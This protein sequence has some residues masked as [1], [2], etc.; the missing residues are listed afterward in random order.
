MSPCPSCAA[1]VPEAARFCSSCGAPASSPSSPTALPSDARRL[2]SPRPVGHV[3]TPAEGRGF[4][5]GAVLAERFRIIGLLGRGGMGEVY[6]ADDLKLGQPVALKFLPHASFQDAALIDRLH[7]EVRNARQI[8]HPSVCRVYDIGEVNGDHFITMEYVDG[9]DLATLLSRIGRLPG[10]KALEIARQLCGGLA[11]AHEKGVLHRDLKPANV[12][13]DGHGHARITDFGLALRTEEAAGDKSGTPA[14]MAPE[15]L[16]GKPASVRSDIYALGL[17]LYELYTGKPAF[18]A[19]NLAAWKRQ[20]SETE[21]TAPSSHAADVD[22]A[23]ERAILRCLEK[24]PRKRPGSALQ[25][26]AALP[27]GDPLAAA[28]AAGETPSPEMVAAAGETEGLRPVIAWLCLAGIV[29]GVVAAVL[30]SG[31]AKLYRRVPLEKPPEA[32]AERAKDVLRSVGHAEPPADSA[33]GFYEGNDFLR[34]VSEHDASK[35]R[36]DNMEYGPFAFW[37]RSSPRPLGAHDFAT[38]APT[39]GAVWTDDPPLDVSGM[40]LVRLTPRGHLVQLVVVP[41]QVEDSPGAAVPVDWG[42]LFVAAGLD[43]SKWTSAQST[44]TP[45]VYSDTRA[46]WTGALAERPEMPMRIEAAAYRGKPVYFQLIGPMT[47]PEREQAYKPTPAERAAQVAGIFLLLLL[48][49][50]SAILARRNLRLGRGDRRGAFRLA[51]VVFA[52]SAVAFLLGAH[53]VADFYEFALFFAAL[54]LG[55]A[56]SFYIGIIYIALEPYVRRRWPA[57][58]ISWSRLLAGGVLDPL[59]GRDVLF[60]CLLSITGICVVRL[61]WFV[62]LWLGRPPVQPY[63]GPTWQ[64]LGARAIIST[65]SNGIIFAILAGLASL[66]I[67]F[68]FRTLLRKD[69]AAAV[70]FVLFVGLVGATATGG[71]IAVVLVPRLILAAL[72]VFL[73]IRFGVLALVAANV[74]DVFLGSFPL[75]TQMSSWYADISLA[76]MLLMAAIAFYAFYISLGGRSPFG[77][78]DLE[79]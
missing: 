72:G 19:A 43:A 31:Q 10:A 32:L 75:T 39:G 53:H 60:G 33:F 70:A 26:A 34:Y 20:H 18:E 3:S 54:S 57:T 1:E 73:L 55:I 56:G 63:S 12:M 42:Q 6:R 4:A 24:D 47:R 2:L 29:L 68:L 15:Q 61:A 44:W 9:E 41:A 62:P 45:P 8:S 71:S 22:P 78:S 40:T 7:G 48:L 67:L 65:L 5:P 59:V 76:G 58:L 28:L 11:A 37:Y 46:A 69:W 35:T 64:L 66:A 74:F 50:G 30:M 13:I 51:T 16:E 14:Y 38:D 21:P 23:V 52:A 36:W 77:A 79:E 27:G 25:V 17:V 49:T